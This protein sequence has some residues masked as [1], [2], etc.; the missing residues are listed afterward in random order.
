MTLDQALRWYDDGTLTVLEAVAIITKELAP[1]TAGAVLD[2][3]RA[4]P[5]L[6]EELI[7]T[8]RAWTAESYWLSVG[9]GARAALD[10]GNLGGL[11]RVRDLARRET[12]SDVARKVAAWMQE[13]ADA[14]PSFVPD[15]VART[16]L[17]LAA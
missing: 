5:E 7:T 3:L 15:D 10:D 9:S 1:E 11:E 16:N 2:R 14:E 6:R 12:Y 8:A 4:R 17:E 13:P